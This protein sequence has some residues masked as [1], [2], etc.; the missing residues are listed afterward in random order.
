MTSL[1]ALKATYPGAQA[2]RFGDG[3]DL[4][5]ELTALVVSG[6][7]TATCGRLSDY[8]EGDPDRPVVGRRDIACLWDW[9]PA[10]VTETVKVTERRFRD[11]PEDFAL[12]EGEGTFEEWRRGHETYFG[13][14]GGF[15]PG[16]WLLCERFRVVEVVG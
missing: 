3:P 8:P 4:C 6:A 10:C 13:R 7:K 2:Y 16:M 15:D 9:T 5:A 14:N 11:V 12:A 1:E